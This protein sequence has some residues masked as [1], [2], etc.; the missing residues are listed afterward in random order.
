MENINYLYSSSHALAEGHS[1]RMRNPPIYICPSTTS[2]IPSLVQ[3]M[4]VRWTGIPKPQD[5]NNSA[6]QDQWNKLTQ[7]WHTLLYCWRSECIV[8]WLNHALAKPSVMLED[9][10]DVTSVTPTGFA[11][12]FLQLESCSRSH[13]EYTLTILFHRIT[14]KNGI[15]LI[16]RSGNKFNLLKPW[17]LDSIQAML[18][19]SSMSPQSI[20]FEHKNL[21]VWIRTGRG[22]TKVKSRKLGKVNCSWFEFSATHIHTQAYFPFQTYWVLAANIIFPSRKT[23]HQTDSLLH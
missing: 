22:L 11:K 20:G 18:E 21:Q 14:P 23:L 1:R 12:R 7:Q 19:E 3:N 5:V 13:N 17:G 6:W 15:V 4:P 2:F 8:I 16:T 9:R 10:C